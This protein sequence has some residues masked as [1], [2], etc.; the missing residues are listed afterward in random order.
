[1]VKARALGGGSGTHAEQATARR[2]ARLG[3]F[4]EAAARSGVPARPGVE[5]TW[6]LTWPKLDVHLAVELSPAALEEWQLTALFR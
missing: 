4:L 3:A 6:R 1:L 5:S 2:R